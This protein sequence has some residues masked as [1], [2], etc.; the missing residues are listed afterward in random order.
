MNE[1]QKYD[2]YLLDLISLLQEAVIRSLSKSTTLLHLETLDV[3]KFRHYFE[4]IYTHMLPL[5]EKFHS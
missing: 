1:D 5:E 2:G 3:H 4:H